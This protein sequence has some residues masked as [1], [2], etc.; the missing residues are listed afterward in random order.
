MDERGI[1]GQLLYGYDLRAVEIVLDGTLYDI[2]RSRI[3]VVSFFFCYIA[4]H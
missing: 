2:M 4:S 1:E 3:D